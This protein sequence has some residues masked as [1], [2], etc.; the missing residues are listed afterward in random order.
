MR[1]NRPLIIHS[2]IT[3]IPP[4]VAMIIFDMSSWNFN[5]DLSNAWELFFY[6]TGMLSLF[7]FFV[8]KINL[9]LIPGTLLLRALVFY[10]IYSLTKIHMKGE[11]VWYVVNLIIVLITGFL[12]H[13]FMI[14]SNQ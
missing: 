8:G 4:I 13:F 12:G 1:L 10:I 3:V 5:N 2:I 9:I 7:L 11:Y 14:M 6:T